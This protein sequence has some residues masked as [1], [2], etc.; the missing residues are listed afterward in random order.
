M[1]SPA[2]PIHNMPEPGDKQGARAERQRAGQGRAGQGRAIKHN[3]SGMQREPASPASE[4]EVAVGAVTGM[5]QRA[6]G[7]IPGLRPNTKP[8]P[9]RSSDCTALRAVFPLRALSDYQMGP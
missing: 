6:G 2:H 8:K 5:W 4:T 1:P 9:P 7:P 3:G